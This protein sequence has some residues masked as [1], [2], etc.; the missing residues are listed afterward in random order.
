MDMQI[1]GQDGPQSWGVLAVRKTKYIYVAVAGVGWGAGGLD[2]ARLRR[3][4]GA[5]TPMKRQPHDAQGKCLAL[6][7]TESKHREEVKGRCGGWTAM[8]VQEIYKLTATW[9]R[10]NVLFA[11][12]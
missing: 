5:G 10:V 2:T 11:G 7:W 12:L 8:E 4:P 1:K 3:G 9:G 6:H